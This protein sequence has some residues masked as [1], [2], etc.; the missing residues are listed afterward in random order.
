[1]PA[2]TQMER[3]M[4]TKEVEEKI[5]ALKLN[6]EVAGKVL[7]RMLENYILKGETYIDK[8]LKLN[9]RGD[10]PRQFVINLYNDT[11]R[12]DCVKIEALVNKEELHT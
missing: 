10:I 5:Y 6:Y 2:K 9:V 11:S 3:M 12:N 4:S 1:M 8:K 7:L